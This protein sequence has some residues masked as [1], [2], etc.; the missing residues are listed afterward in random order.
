MPTPSLLRNTVP[1]VLRVALVPE[2]RARGQLCSLRRMH[3][4]QEKTAGAGNRPD[5][6]TGVKGEQQRAHRPGSSG[7]ETTTAGIAATRGARC[8]PGPPP[9]APPYIFMVPLG[10]KLVR[11]TSCSP[12]AALMLTANAAWARATSALGFRVF[13]AAIT[14]PAAEEEKSRREDRPQPAQR[15]PAALSGS[16]GK[17]GRALP[18]PSVPTRRPHWAAGRPAPLIGSW[19]HGRPP[20]APP[21]RPGFGAIVQGGGERVLER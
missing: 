1:R 8:P 19:S 20:A 7:L 12:R 13:T 3:R 11:S 15:G 4:L 21:S 16:S 18:A 14:D 17:V 6:G 10:P 5:M 2:I 9:P